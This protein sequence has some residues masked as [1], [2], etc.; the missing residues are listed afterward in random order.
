M[1]C[2][3]CPHPLNLGYP[4]PTKASKIQ[5]TLF[6]KNTSE[7][8]PNGGAAGQCKNK[9]QHYAPTSLYTSNKHNRKK[10]SDSM[11]GAGQ[12]LDKPCYVD[13]KVMKN[14]RAKAEG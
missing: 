13:C 1:P 10:D 6:W 4:T 7:S 12:K 2:L 8:N 5:V 14:E 3:A 9:T 11:K